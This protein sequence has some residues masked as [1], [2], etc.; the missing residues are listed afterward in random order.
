MSAVDTSIRAIRYV[1]GRQTQSLAELEAAGQLQ[2]SA[3][4]MRRFGFGQ[5]HV[6]TGESPF[7]L[8]LEAGRALLEQERIDPDSIDLLV[9]G[10]VPGPLGFESA[11]GCWDTATAARTTARFK[12][13]ATRLAYELGLTNAG[14][15]G[16]SQLAC[17]TLFSAVRI[18][19]AMCH[20]GDVRRV[21][22]INAEFYPPDSGRE[23]LFN[24]TSDAA[25]ALLVEQGGERLLIRGSSQVTKGYYWD[26]DALRNEIV[27]SYFPTSR[28][29]VQRVLA[30]AGWD[31]AAVRWVIPH[32]VSRRSWDV[33]MGLLQLPNATL[34]ADNIARNGHTLAGDNFINLADA[35]AAGQ[36]ESGDKLL[37]FSYG[38][39][40]HWTA[41]AVEA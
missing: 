22:C 29:A 31:A 41:L 17:T 1:L 2:S 38:Y 35:I 20:A 40:A 6:A 33:L 39:G 8:A 9:H 3:D 23:T 18:A 10:G 4:L 13:P 15:F 11:A 7:E 28:H 25:V 14:V 12:Y 16:L 36:I 5:V 34:W 32:N 24:C 26:C 37:L 27:A 21:L 19:R 30:A